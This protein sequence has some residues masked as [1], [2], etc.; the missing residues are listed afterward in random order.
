[1]RL[2]HWTLAACAAEIRANG[3]RPSGYHSFC[4]D[5]EGVYFCTDP[6]RHGPPVN[7]TLLVVEIAEEQLAEGCSEECLHE[8][9]P[10][11]ECTHPATDWK[12]PTALADAGLLPEEP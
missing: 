12:I 6:E 5:V 7:D 1:M 8:G 2:Y 10:S 3:F 11:D 4:P 9:C